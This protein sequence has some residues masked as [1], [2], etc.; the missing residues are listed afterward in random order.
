MIGFFKKIRDAHGDNSKAEHQDNDFGTTQDIVK[1]GDFQTD[2]AFVLENIWEFI[3]KSESS[4]QS[5]VPSITEIENSLVDLE[6]V[7]CVKSY[8]REVTKQNAE[9]KKLYEKAKDLM[10]CN[11]SIQEKKKDGMWQ[12][13]KT[14]GYNY[15]LCKID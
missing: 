12:N 15:R 1:K 14:F 5:S 10:E 9:W 7:Y 3:A 2:I 11:G 4:I 8:I 13:Y 6:V